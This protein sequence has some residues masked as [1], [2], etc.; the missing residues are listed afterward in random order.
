MDGGFNQND[1]TTGLG[2]A[3]IDFTGN[4]VE[5]VANVPGIGGIAGTIAAPDS[6]YDPTGTTGT[7]QKP[8]DNVIL[9]LFLTRHPLQP[10]YKRKLTW[11]LIHWRSWT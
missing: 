2:G 3:V 7:P 1:P 4:N 5:N 6:T 9:T 11:A 8:D 10:K